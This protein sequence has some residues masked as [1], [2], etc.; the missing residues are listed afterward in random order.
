[1]ANADR[2]TNLEDRVRELEQRL[3]RAERARLAA[4]EEVAELRVELAHAGERGR[5]AA[6][7]TERL[8]EG[9]EVLGEARDALSLFAEVLRVLGDVLEFD[10]AFVVGFAPEVAPQIV[11]ATDA[12]LRLIAWPGGAFTDRVL[13]GR[14]VALFD[15]AG[16]PE[17]RRVDPALREAYTSALHVPLHAL[18][19]Q[20][21]LVCLHRRRGFFTADRVTRARRFAALAR[22]AL[23]TAEH[24]V[25]LEDDR[26]RAVELSRAKSSFVAS[27]SH[28]LR[29]PLNAIIGYC[30]HLIEDPVAQRGPELGETLGRI[31]LSARMLRE[32]IGNVLDLGKIE[33]GRLDLH[34]GPVAVAEVCRLALVTALPLAVR[35]GNVIRVDVGTGLP[36]LR[37]DAGKLRQILVNLLA[38]ACSFTEAG[39]IDLVV[40]ADRRGEALVFQVRDTGQGLTPAESAAVFLPFAQAGP[41]DPRRL[42]GTGLGLSIAKHFTERLGGTIDL[43]SAVGVGTTFTVRLPLAGP[44]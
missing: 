7:H 32:L 11:S 29:T 17:W 13:A 23:Q 30:E 35:R 2:E 19:S 34:V 4:E 26:G 24:L 41:V 38:N 9:L 36:E 6:A 20:A 18:H 31:D 21:M 16:N 8:L 27:M 25:D 12:R 15:L 39:A 33:A 43:D 22:Q 14:T 42:G 37:S 40:R 5:V 28:E 3:A 1:M 10:A 44:P